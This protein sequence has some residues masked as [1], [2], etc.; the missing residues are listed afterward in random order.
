MYPLYT[1]IKL[2]SLIPSLIIAHEAL[3]T[4]K[5]TEIERTQNEQAELA[6][7]QAKAIAAKVVVPSSSS[8][9]SSSS[10]Q[11]TPRSSIKEPTP[12][13]PPETPRLET[14]IEVE[15]LVAEEKPLR[16]CFLNCDLFFFNV[17]SLF[18]IVRRENL[19]FLSPVIPAIITFV[20]WNVC[21][22]H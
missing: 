3:L 8:S 14:P 11:S 17:Y 9:S 13:P 4:E 5:L 1:I 21:S 7:E 19:K 6:A 15:V 12:S 16:K 2:T 22:N 20:Q 10:A 18:S